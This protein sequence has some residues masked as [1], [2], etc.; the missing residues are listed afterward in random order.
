MKTSPWKTLAPAASL[1][2]TLWGTPGSLL[3]NAI[4]KAWSAGALSSVWSKAM[5][6]ADTSTT[7]PAA[8]A[9][10]PGLP[11][12]AAEAGALGAAEAGAG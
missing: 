1:I 8:D 11:L 4:W 3:A 2:A 5:F 9:L 6:W 12:G 7:V 10:G